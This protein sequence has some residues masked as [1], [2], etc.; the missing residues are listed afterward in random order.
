MTWA[1]GE[2]AFLKY[3]L[4]SP[5]DLRAGTA[6]SDEEGAGVSF[7]AAAVAA[8]LE[9]CGVRAEDL[10]R[11]PSLSDPSLVAEQW[12]LRRVKPLAKGGKLWERG[13][14]EEWRPDACPGGGTGE[15]Y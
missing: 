14:L 12:T 15:C 8:Y 1:R 9:R 4:A 5:A 3:W 10:R 13:Y 11:I 7:V 2:P 6:L